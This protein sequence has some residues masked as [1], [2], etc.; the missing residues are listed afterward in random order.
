MTWVCG[1]I[2]D[3]AQWKASTRE[4]TGDR[5]I[6]PRQHD[7]RYHWEAGKLVLVVAVGDERIDCRS[8]KREQ[9]RCELT[10]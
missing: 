4:L 6:R 3:W 10:E 2:Q 8:M 7:W 9:I 1:M 5:R